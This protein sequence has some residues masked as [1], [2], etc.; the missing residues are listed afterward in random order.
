MV[1]R[2]VKEFVVPMVDDDG[3]GTEKDDVVLE[4]SFWCISD[5]PI[6]IG[7]DIRLNALNDGF[8]KP[9]LGWIEISK[10]RLSSHFEIAKGL[11]HHG[12]YVSDGGGGM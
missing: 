6:L 5:E 7:A 2:C 8:Y 12:G 10:N 4:G 3:F 1:Y 9:T 11:V